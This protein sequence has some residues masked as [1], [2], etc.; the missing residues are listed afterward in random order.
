MT[1]FYYPSKIILNIIYLY[2]FILSRLTVLKK[3]MSILF[4]NF[5]LIIL[6]FIKIYWNV[7]FSLN[8]SWP[9]S[10]IL[11]YMF[12]YILKKLME[13]KKVHVYSFSKFYFCYF[14]FYLNSL[15]C[16]FFIIPSKSFHIL[17]T[18]SYNRFW[19]WKKVHFTCFL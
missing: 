19:N 1:T 9:S 5:I 8:P 14:I 2:Y 11:Y 18:L 16:T 4:P 15:T 3:Y 12:L 6:F 13:P 17:F 10:C 7:L